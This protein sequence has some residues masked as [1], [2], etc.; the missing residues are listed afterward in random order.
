MSQAKPWRGIIPLKST[1]AEVERLLGKPNGLG[2]YQFDDERAYIHYAEK[3]CGRAVDCE[4][5]APKDTVLDI[6]V[7][8]E[9]EMKFS[10]LHIDR[11][12]YEKPFTPRFVCS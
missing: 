8:V 9:V 2:R 10:K 5:L 11:G 12:K 7:T 4:C 1:R 3:P 6:F